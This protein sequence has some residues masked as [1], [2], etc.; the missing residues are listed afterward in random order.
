M[1][2]SIRWR[3]TLWNLLALAAV[4]LGFSSLVYVLLVRALYQQVDDKLL[5]GFRVLERDPRMRDDSDGRL[6]YWIHEL[7]EHD[8]IFAVA[9]DSEGR[10]HAR[11]EEMAAASV[12]ATAPAATAQPR[13]RDQ[14]VEALGRQRIAEGRVR[15]GDQDFTLTLM[16]P[17][18][19]VD[20]E[21]RRLLM[22]LVLAVPVALVLSGGVSYLLARKAMAPVARLRTLAREITADR[23]DRRLEVANPDDELGGLATTINE[24]IGRLERS[25]AEIRRFT[26]DASHELRTPLAAL[27]AEAE[28][29]LA[30][31]SVAPEQQ[32]LL[33]SILEEC[34]RL[35]RLTDQLLTLAREDA[36]IGPTLLREDV[37]LTA[38]VTAVAETMRPLAVTRA[39]HLHVGSPP[40]RVRGDAARLRQVFY[41]LVDNAIKYTPE[42][43]TVEVRVETLGTTAVAT[44]RDTGIGIPAEHLPHLFERFYRVD[45]A[46]TREQGGTGLGLSIAR[47]IVL[48]HGGHI[49][50]E[51]T[52]GQGTTARVELPLDST[53]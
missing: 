4:L 46:R 28:V 26:A 42:G 24:M 16:S 5:A 13:L 29:A 6:R 25:F 50:L 20:R 32:A 51:S 3:L 35:T 21:R 10:V 22:A 47:S 15:L 39:I 37:D 43:G 19:G 48:A 18:E 2:L 53:V 44:V 11:T 49:K 14:T 31:P 34:E 7:H 23:L 9:Y 27:R 33:G 1:G 52:P 36:G 41:N 8:D 38:L 30:R 40:A 12:P 45:K 17:L